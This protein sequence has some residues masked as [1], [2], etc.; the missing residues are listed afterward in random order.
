ML[1]FGI[2]RS[3][4]LLLNYEPPT[5]LE[6][7]CQLGR[8][9]A[10]RFMHVVFPAWE[11]TISCNFPVI[12]LYFSCVFP[13]FFLYFSCPLVHFSALSCTFLHFQLLLSHLLFLLH[14]F[15]AYFFAPIPRIS[16]LLKSFRQSPPT[17]RSYIAKAFFCLRTSSISLLAHTIHFSAHALVIALS[18]FF[19]TSCLF[20]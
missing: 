15:Y 4:I 3:C 9:D 7:L 13:V 5:R 20:P 6:Q 8:P 1:S 16:F 11:W 2:E 18:S 17:R 14:T 19:V 10:L 12:L